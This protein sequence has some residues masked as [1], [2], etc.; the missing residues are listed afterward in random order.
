MK[1]SSHFLIAAPS[2]NSGKTTLTLGLLRALKNRGKNVQPFKCGPDYIDPIHH[3]PAA[4]NVS[5]NLDTFMASHKH[6]SE[7][8]EMYGQDADVCVTEGVMGLFDGAD[9]M[10][11]SSAAIAELLDIPV[12]LVINAKSM[13]YS[14]APLLYGFKNFY[15]GIRV[16]GAIFNFVNSESHYRFLREACEDVDIEALGYL[17]KNENISIA[18]RHLGLHISSETDYESVIENLAAAVSETVDIDLLLRITRRKVMDQGQMLPANNGFSNRKGGL[19]ITIAKDE[20]FS[21]TYHQ[22]IE[23]LSQF[24][25]ISWFSPVQDAILPDTDFLY[26]PGGYPELFAEKLSANKSMLAS[27]KRYCDGG[28]VTY[29]ECGGMMYLGTEMINKEGVTFEM[30]GVL[31]YATTMSGTK[32]TLGY[33]VAH[34]NELEFKGHEFHYSAFYEQREAMV[35]IKVNNAKGAEVITPFFKKNNTVATYMHVY[36]GEHAVFI[37]QLMKCGIEM[38]ETKIL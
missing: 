21:F 13:A 24:G 32:M 7:L 28:G 35:E 15:P 33:R 16:V 31:D 18:S 26:L 20:A 27:I 10:Q 12:I 8:Y 29:A 17:A 14:A 2:S 19:K 25:E 37:E 1:A 30:A 11:G 6:V 34:W 9:K 3:T 4:G 5:I 22:N 23:V 38:Q 36:W